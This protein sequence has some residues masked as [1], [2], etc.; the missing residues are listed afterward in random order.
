MK[1][2][3]RDIENYEGLYQV[4]NFGQIRSI[5]RLVKQRLGVRL[6]KG[7]ILKPAQNPKGYFAVSLCKENKAHTF[8]VHR[9]VANAFIPNPYNLATVNHKNI[10]KTDNRLCNLERLSLLDNSKHAQING[11]YKKFGKLQ[12]QQ[13]KQIKF[14]L[15]YKI[16]QRVLAKIYGV[17]Q[18]IIH[19]I[20]NSK[21][22]YL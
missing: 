8:T 2:Q 22:K 11:C 17:S 5:D 4:S 9:L 1:A 18:P 15:Q 10:I 19:R 7:Q 14:L 21:T 3:W 20:K 6:A 13:I 16:P 12:K